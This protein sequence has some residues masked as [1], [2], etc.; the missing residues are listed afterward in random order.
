MLCVR[1]QL[2]KRSKLGVTCIVISCHLARLAADD[3]VE[4][5]P[6]LGR[7]RRNLVACNEQKSIMPTLYRRVVLKKAAYIVRIAA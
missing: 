7:R 3:A 1:A 2:K 4:R 6:G 5:R